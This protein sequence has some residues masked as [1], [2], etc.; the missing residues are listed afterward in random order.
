MSAVL[1][2]LVGL[3]ITLLSAL[4]VVIYL[5]AHLKAILIDL[6]GTGERAG[7]WTAFSNVTLMLVPLIFALNY[8]PEAGSLP[9]LVFELSAQLK[10][11]LIGLV[12][13][14]VVLGI[15]MSSFIRR[16]E[17]AGAPAQERRAA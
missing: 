10:N 2:F 7:F 11:A 8:R 17:A 15:V 14:V 4:L 9:S 16:R 12:C 13:S 1:I 5:R 6:C 3:A